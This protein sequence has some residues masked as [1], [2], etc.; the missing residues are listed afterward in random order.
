MNLRKV[1]ETKEKYSFLNGRI[2]RKID[3]GENDLF[4]VNKIVIAPK[5]LSEFSKDFD[6]YFDSSNPSEL[7]TNINYDI[8]LFKSKNH[9]EFFVRIDDAISDYKIITTYEQHLQYLKE[10]YEESF[11]DCEKA[12]SRLSNESSNRTTAFLDKKLHDDIVMWEKEKIKR[13]G[14]VI[15]FQKFIDNSVHNPKAELFIGFGPDDF[16]DK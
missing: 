5:N 7:P 15:E 11:H 16:L 1:K 3:A 2:I 9:P 4:P 8:Y 13:W 6:K 10:L 12:K 14:K